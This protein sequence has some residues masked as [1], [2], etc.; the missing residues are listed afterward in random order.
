MKTTVLFGALA[1]VAI[2]MMPAIACDYTHTTAAQ[3]S[4][5]VA[6]AGGKC[7]AQAPTTQQGSGKT[8]AR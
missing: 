3:N 2:G 6:C 5:V 4:T 7:D 1:F 8:E